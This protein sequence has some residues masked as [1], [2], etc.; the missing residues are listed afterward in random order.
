MVRID[1]HRSPQ[2]FLSAWL[3]LATLAAEVAHAQDAPPVPLDLVV[4]TGT[5]TQ[6]PAFDVPAA[7]TG[8]GAEAL[9]NAGPLVNLSEALV[10]VPGLTVLN[11]Q[12]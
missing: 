8:V 5:R 3:I 6:T 12:N 11:R 10:R 4:V 9:R 1:L 2:A 7:I